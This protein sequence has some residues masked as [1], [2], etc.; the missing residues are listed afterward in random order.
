[1]FNPLGTADI[2]R[3]VLPSDTEGDQRQRYSCNFAKYSSLH[4]KQF[5]NYM[6]VHAGKDVIMSIELTK[7]WP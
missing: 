6:K 1:M 4:M 5:Y 2:R 7:N 3:V